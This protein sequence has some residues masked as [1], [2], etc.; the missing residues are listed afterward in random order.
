MADIPYGKIVRRTWDRENFRDLSARKVLILTHL[1]TCPEAEHNPI[2]FQISPTRIAKRLSRR[3]L[4][5]TPQTVRIALKEL[6][7]AGWIAW[8]DAN[9]LVGCVKQTKFDAPANANVLRHWLKSAQSIP[10]S[11]FCLRF[12]KAI[13][14]WV[15][16]WNLTEEFEALPKAFH[17]SFHDTF[18]ETLPESLPETSSITITIPITS[19]SAIAKPLPQKTESGTASYAQGARSPLQKLE[20]YLISPTSQVLISGYR[21]KIGQD[22]LEDELIL[23][24]RFLTHSKTMADPVDFLV[25]WLDPIV[26]QISRSTLSETT[27]G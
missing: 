26:D 19:S 13:K 20:E 22:R 21:E 10:D 16:R 6:S 5:Q 17:G 18:Q 1:W 3:D 8:D 11:P 14:P 24:R 7:E 15:T 2:L 12:A 4:K 9:E 25:T 23:M 27:E